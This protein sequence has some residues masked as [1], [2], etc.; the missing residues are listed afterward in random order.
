VSDTVF[1]WCEDL[2]KERGFE[3]RIVFGP[4]VWVEF[5]EDV[6]EDAQQ[7][8]YHATAETVFAALYKLVLKAL[9]EETD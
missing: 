3:L 2:A 8:V 6:G 5:W 9:Q 1:T 4:P 7:R